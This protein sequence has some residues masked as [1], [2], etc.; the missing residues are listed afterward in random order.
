MCQA[1]LI[2]WS[3]DGHWLFPFRGYILWVQMS[4]TDFILWLYFTVI[5]L[6]RL[7]EVS[8]DSSYGTL[9]YLGRLSSWSFKTFP[10]KLC[11]VLSTTDSYTCGLE[12]WGEIRQGIRMSRLVSWMLEGGHI[13]GIAESLWVGQKQQ[14]TMLKCCKADFLPGTGRGSVACPCQFHCKSCSTLCRHA[15]IVEACWK[16]RAPRK[17]WH[18]TLFTF[19]IRNQREAS[20]RQQV[21]IT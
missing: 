13:K 5:S 6:L 9:N 17:G 11:R 20:T 12:L 21:A 18:K 16:H 3:A 8:R 10:W 14:Q 1:F 4:L 15:K 19:F 7:G 2:H